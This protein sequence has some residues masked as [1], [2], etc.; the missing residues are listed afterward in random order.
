[1][2]DCITRWWSILLAGFQNSFV[3]TARGISGSSFRLDN[4]IKP[5][6][7]YEWDI[8]RN[9]VRAAPKMSSACSRT[10]LYHQKIRSAQ[11]SSFSLFGLIFTYSMGALIVIISFIV[12]PILCF[13]QK[14]GRYNRYA[15]LEWEGHTSIQLHRVAQD[16]CGYG[17][18][19]HCDEEIPITRPGDMLAAFDISNPKHPM[20][21]AS[22]K[23]AAP[24]GTPSEEKSLPSDQTPQE[25]SLEPSDEGS[26]RHMSF[27]VRPATADGCSQG[28]R[29]DQ[30]PGIDEG[31]EGNQ[32]RRN[33]AP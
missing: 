33:T 29:S 7:E 26:S 23:D 4:T 5:A 32:T 9:Q 21:A 2:S 12:S 20:L 16:Q 6:N 22:N 27:A 8:C 30:F 31:P 25:S 10:N 28:P 1:M 3:S 11:Y 15:Y 18:W 24:E 19:S 13:L 17:R 14:R